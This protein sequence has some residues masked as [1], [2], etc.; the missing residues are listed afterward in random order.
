MQTPI[1]QQTIT[2]MRE[3]HKMQETLEKLAK[4]LQELKSQHTSEE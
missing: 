2:L 4:S 3:M 1:E